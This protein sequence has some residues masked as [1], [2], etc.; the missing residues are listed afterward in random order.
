MKRNALLLAWTGLLL[1]AA[2]PSQAQTDEPGKGVA[3]ISLINGDVSVRRGD[4]GDW[5][6]AVINAPLLADDRVLTG[7]ASR[8]EV[9][10]DYYHR[11][12]LAADT[13]IR[14]TQLEHRLYQIQVVRGTVTFSALKGGDAQ[15]ELNTP[16]AALRP[17]AWGEYRITVDDE[18]RAELTV[19]R[20][21][22]EIYTPERSQRLRPGRT[23][24]ARLDE[25]NRAETRL[26]AEIPHDRWDEFNQARDREL[27]R[28]A[29]VYRYVS[30]DIYGAE[31]LDGYGTWIYV[32]PYGWCWR[33]FVAVGWAPYRLGR[34]IWLDW[35]GWTWISYDPWGWAPYHYGRWFWWDNAWLWYPGPV[36]GVRHWWSPA[37]VGWFGWSSWGGFAAGVGFGWGAVGWVPLAP[38]EPLYPWWGP[39]FA[40][41]R[42]VNYVYQNTTIIHNTNITNIYRNARVRDAITV[43]RGDDFV[44]GHTGRPLRLGGEELARASVARGALPFAPAR[45][46]LRWSDREPAVRRA[47]LNA[48]RSERFFS[49]MPAARAE[50]VPFDEQRRILEQWTLRNDATRT[51]RE[52]FAERNGLPGEPPEAAGRGT[53]R[54]SVRSADRGGTAADRGWRRADEPRRAETRATENEWRRFG[55]PGVGIRTPEGAR[56]RPSETE[57]IRTRSEARSEESSR[58][59]AGWRSFGDPARSPVRSVDGESTVRRSWNAGREAE[60]AEPVRALPQAE[61]PRWSTGRAAE[62][63]A[64]DT[65]RSQRLPWSTG[66]GRERTETPGWTGPHSEPPRSESLRWSTGGTRSEDGGLRISPAPRTETPRLERQ[67]EPVRGG[68]ERRATPRGER[69]SQFAPMSR[70]G[71]STAGVTAGGAPGWNVPAADSPS[72]PPRPAD[73]AAGIL[74]LSPRRSTGGDDIRISPGGSDSWHGSGLRAAPRSERYAPAPPMTRGGWSTGGAAAIGGETPVTAPPHFSGGEVTGGGRSS[75]RTGA[76][77]I[78]SSPRIEPRSNGSWSAGGRTG[79]AADG[80]G[81]ATPSISVPRSAPSISVPRSAPSYGG[82]AGGMRSAPGFGGSGIGAAPGFGGG[83]IRG[84]AMSAPPGGSGSGIRGGGFGGGG[85]RSTG[86][87]LGAPAVGGGMRG[88]RGR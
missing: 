2:L 16:A 88:G 43:V 26:I 44:R 34:W 45:E 7:A 52:T 53:E 12:R 66:R 5:V 22:A 10:F 65:P 59:S 51:R 33:P 70:G 40:G 30:R 67:G 64:A 23:L 62:S 56:S 82:H 31:D 83:G 55:D 38:F 60:P 46:S 18:D 41:Y 36:I 48:G 61:S 68:E 74:D 13:E 9:Q 81:S 54:S 77:V 14:L 42:N 86:P 32:A 21:E 29:R 28:A 15:V 6:A 4:S 78:D 20:G 17:L 27:A 63:P 79:W 3:R 39:R 57:G 8:A 49:R 50:R 72:S 58:G 76:G 73:A 84:G 24:V 1:A 47:E 19:R 25:S 75:W 11:I 35:Y 80:L 37:L 87:G 85:F 69:G 71:W